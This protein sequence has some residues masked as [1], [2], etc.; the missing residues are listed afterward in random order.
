M[1]ESDRVTVLESGTANGHRY[2][3][4]QTD[5]GHFCGYVRT[6]F[7]PKWT[8]EDIR[9]R[10][11]HLVDCHGGLTYGVD[12]DGWVGFDCAHAGDVCVLD[13]DEQ[14]DHAMSTERTWTPEDVAEECEKVAEQIDIL[15]T[16]AEQ[17]EGRGW[18][19]DDG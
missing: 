4:R 8:Y 10:F 9:G 1:S 12:E 7:G 13:G 19:H 18:G 15:E 17:F 2:E 16:F 3:V 5:M 14:T 11:S 6:N